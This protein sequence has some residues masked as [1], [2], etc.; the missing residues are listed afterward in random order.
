MLNVS[1]QVE[2]QYFHQAIKHLEWREAIKVELAAM[3]SNHTWSV[4][5]LPIGK[6]SIGCR[7]VF[8]IKYNFDGSIERHK[9]RLVAKGY[10]QQEG[11][12]YF[13]TFSPVAKIVTVKVLL[14]LVA[15][16]G[17][18]LF[19]LDVNNAF[20]NGGL[21]E[22]VYMDLPPGYEVHTAGK[23]GEKLVCKLHKSIYGFKQASRQWN[24]KFTQALIQYGFTQSKAD[25]SLLTK[26]F[27]DKFVALLVYVDDIV[28]T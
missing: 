6:N 7:W 24:S 8:K 5:S 27:G 2:P 23:K 10:T 17:W 3:E 19:Q 9:A 14:A 12:D 21:F 16:R 28:I 13:D 20:L 22:E 1:S 25:Y 15:S 4:T 18:H 11:L 26:G